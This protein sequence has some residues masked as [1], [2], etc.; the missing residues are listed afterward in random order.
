VFGRPERKTVCECE[1][2]SDT[3]LAQVL[4]LMN[5]APVNDRIVSPTGR[6]AKLAGSEATTD[7]IITELYLAALNRNPQPAELEASR[8]AFNSPD[9][10]RRQA[11][12]DVLWALINTAEFVLNH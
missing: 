4:H 11:T 12:E 10:N 2:T 7:E 6:A 5:A 3:S 1:R 8:K 9:S